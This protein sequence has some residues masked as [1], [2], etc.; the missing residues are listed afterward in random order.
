MKSRTFTRVVNSN[1]DDTCIKKNSLGN[2]G[3]RSCPFYIKNLLL[4]RVITI[5]LFKKYSLSEGD[6]SLLK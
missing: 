2:S 1:I 5:K 4:Q 3:E 6:L